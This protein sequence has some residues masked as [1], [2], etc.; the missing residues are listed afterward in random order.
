ML[1]KDILLS[2]EN[3]I[4][5]RKIIYNQYQLPIISPFSYLVPPV[6]AIFLYLTHNFVAPFS[7]LTAQ[8]HYILS[9]ELYHA[10]SSAWVNSNLD[11]SVQRRRSLFKIP[12]LWSDVVDELPEQTVI[13]WRYLCVGLETSGSY[14]VSNFPR[15][16]EHKHA[17]SRPN[18]IEY[19]IRLLLERFLR[20]YFFL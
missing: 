17:V 6:I 16:S 1:N 14:F 7:H 20:R 5:T 11:P 4:N 15:S 19:F 18:S 12:A 10:K 8:W 3:K 9:R 2:S 13:D